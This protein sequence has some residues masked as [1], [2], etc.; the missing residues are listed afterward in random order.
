MKNIQTQLK[1]INAWSKAVS[2]VV[3]ILFSGCWRKW[4][5]ISIQPMTCLLTLYISQWRAFSHYML[6]SQFACRK[7]FSWDKFP[8]LPRDVST[9]SSNFKLK[10]I[11]MLKNTFFLH[12]QWIFNE[13][14]IWE[15][16][17]KFTR[18]SMNFVFSKFLWE[19]LFCYYYQPRL[20]DEKLQYCKVINCT[21]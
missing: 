5:I 17:W 1:K 18:F 7:I 2:H 20:Q 11:T 19:L 14:I 16:N 9:F 13:T 8:K 21:I 12:M 6:T 10:Y 3:A 4:N 15:S